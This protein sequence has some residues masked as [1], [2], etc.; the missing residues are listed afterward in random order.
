[1]RRE[2]QS[3]VYLLRSVE[4]TGWKRTSSQFS[5]MQVGMGSN[6][7]IGREEKKINEK[8]EKKEKKKREF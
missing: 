5:L 1:M 8:I 7:V 4:F 2:G 6:L 3:S